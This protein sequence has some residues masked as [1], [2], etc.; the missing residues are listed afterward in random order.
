MIKSSL[1]KFLKS[2]PRINYCH[3]RYAATAVNASSQD[4]K[5]HFL[6]PHK[7]KTFITKIYEKSNKTFLIDDYNL[8]PGWTRYFSDLDTFETGVEYLGKD[9]SPDEDIL[10][11]MP[12]YRDLSVRYAVA[13][14]EKGIYYWICEGFEQEI[15]FGNPTIN[16]N[17]TSTIILNKNLDQINIKNFFNKN[18]ISI[19]ELSSAIMQTNFEISNNFTQII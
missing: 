5:A 7:T 18:I 3:L 11:F 2:Q 19:K 14:G 6:D 12:F 8:A 16:L 1:K 13:L 4:K 9:T 15:N 17:K 10:Y